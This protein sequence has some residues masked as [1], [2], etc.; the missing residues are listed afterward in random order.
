MLLKKRYFYG[1]LIALFLVWICPMNSPAE[2]YK[3]VDKD[4]QMFYVDDLSKV[5]PEYLDQVNVYKEKYDHLPADQKKSRLK[6][7]QQQQRELEAEQQRQI[8]LEL[9]KAAEEEES[10][11]NSGDHRKQ[12]GFCAGDHRK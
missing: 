3:Y 1:G 6:K 9:K 8:E 12:S 2:F 4:G 10:Q 5:P 11:R 7:E